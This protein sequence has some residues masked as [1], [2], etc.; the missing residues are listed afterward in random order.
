MTKKIVAVF[1]MLLMLSVIFLPVVAAQADKKVQNEDA[2]LMRNVFDQKL[3][4]DIQSNYGVSKVTYSETDLEDL[5]ILLLK[6]QGI[7]ITELDLSNLEKYTNDSNVILSGLINFKTKDDVQHGINVFS[8]IDIEK[9]SVEMLSREGANYN[10]IAMNKISENKKSIE[11]NIE[12]I[13]VSSNDVKSF[14]YDISQP[15]AEFSQS[16]N[17]NVG[18]IDDFTE[19]LNTFTTRGRTVYPPSYPPPGIGA[20]VVP[21]VQF[22]LLVDSI[23]V[24][25]FISVFIP[26][27]N[28]I[29]FMTGAIA[30]LDIFLRRG[31]NV[32]TDRTYARIWVVSPALLVTYSPPWPA[33]GAGVRSGNN[34]LLG[35]YMEITEYYVK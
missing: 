33:I 35:H 12:Q 2:R 23:A 15:V 24:V 17:R 5:V 11:Y 7:Q 19:Y 18:L 4:S 10:Y 16:L 34:P 3:N 14:N 9:S 22:S 27:G 21:R 25:G 29:G 30:M 20:T 8:N 28:V 31:L 26:G 1:C 13:T 32:D 6:E